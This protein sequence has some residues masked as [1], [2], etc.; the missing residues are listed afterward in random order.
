M[1]RDSDILSRAVLAG[2]LDEF[3]ATD[4]TKMK[5]SGNVELKDF[6][7]KNSESVE[8]FCRLRAEVAEMSGDPEHFDENGRT[9]LN[10]AGAALAGAKIFIDEHR[11]LR[12]LSKKLVDESGLEEDE[13]LYRGLSARQR[14]SLQ[15]RELSNVR[16]ASVVESFVDFQRQM[17]FKSVVLKHVADWAITDPGKPSSSNAPPP[18]CR[19][20]RR[21]QQR[22]SPKKKSERTA[23]GNGKR[24]TVR[25]DR[26]P[27]NAARRHSMY[28]PLDN[29]RIVESYAL[30]VAS[31]VIAVRH[32][33]RRIAA[34]PIDWGD[35]ADGENGLGSQ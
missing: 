15:V 7:A 20:S 5:D 13:F 27:S 6:D 10:L 21:Q 35:D 23:A 3:S 4:L 17:Q 12:S 34:I 1:K 8:E 22:R 19:S 31:E 30:G 14:E 33:K 11:A 16:Q 32:K 18:P 25:L 29:D 24:P 26:T 2:M 9:E 28:N